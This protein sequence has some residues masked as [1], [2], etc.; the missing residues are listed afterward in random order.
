MSL[1]ITQLALNKNSKEF[2][3]NLLIT[4]T[5]EGG[6]IFDIKVNKVHQV[7]ELDQDLTFKSKAELI[8]SFYNSIDKKCMLIGIVK[9]DDT[10]YLC[11][12]Q[13]KEYS[14]TLEENDLLIYI[15]Y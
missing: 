9:G 13:D 2:F 5:K 11:N 14:I 4:D 6:E 15:K 10:I 3:E 7:L 1:L 8:H 12:N